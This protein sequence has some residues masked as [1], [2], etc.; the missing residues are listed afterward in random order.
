MTRSTENAAL[1]APKALPDLPARANQVTFAPSILASDFANLE[2]EVRKVKR[3]GCRWVHID[4]MDNHFVPNLTIGPPVVRSIIRAVPNLFYDAHLMVEQPLRLAGDFIEA[5]VSNV[6][7]H[8]EAT[9]DPAALCRYLRRKKVRVGISLRPRTPV[10]VLA[11][12]LP[13]VD[14]VLV[15]TV[16]P[17]F[18]GQALLPHTLN[19]IRQIKQMREKEQLEF[20]IQADGGINEANVRLVAASGAEVLVMGTAI[21]GQGRVVENVRQLWETLQAPGPAPEGV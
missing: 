12:Y 9:E 13:L 10:R 8:A 4:V 18:G 3:A 15:M 6:T 1:A 16:E 19:K 17:G 5:G 7:I 20:L 11:P 14:L 21:F 2:R